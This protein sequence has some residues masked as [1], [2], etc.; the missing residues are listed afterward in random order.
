MVTFLC[1][2]NGVVTMVNKL[3][4]S[5]NNSHFAGLARNL[6]F[7]R[8]FLGRVITD[9]GDTFYYIGAMWLIWEMTNSPFYTGLAGALI[10]IPN[11]LNF[12]VGPLVDRWALQRVLVSTQLI[13]GLGVLLVP[14][15]A[16]TG[17]LSVWLILLLIPFLQFVNG[18]V[19][20][21]Q[22]AALPQIVDKERLVRANSLFST[23]INAIDMV[24]SGIG[25][26]LIATIGAISL[27]VVNSATF[28]I[29]LL[30]FLGITIPKQ[31]NQHEDLDSDE[32]P[33]SNFDDEPSDTNKTGAETDS[34]ETD[35]QNES[36]Y[37][38]ELREGIEYIRGSTLF[39][40]LLAAMFVNSILIAVNAILPA[41]ASSI[42]GPTAYG[43]LAAAI[44]AGN[45]LGSGGSF[46]VEDYPLSWVIIG[47]FILAGCGWTAAIA[48]PGVVPTGILMTLAVIPVGMFNVLFGSMLQTAVENRLLGRVSSIMR[49]FNS[50]LMPAGA[51]L[52]GT[53]AGI[54]GTVTVMYAV[55]GALV[56]FSLYYLI[57]PQLRS[58]PPVTEIDEEM[59]GL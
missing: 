57:H 58:L 59:L 22:N 39:L 4:E 28:A 12:L 14:A 46:L 20:P 16:V 15:A 19:Y 29:A 11:A 10:Q 37:F 2:C 24:A 54:T 43:L 48:V 17:H 53:A 32:V 47:G 7:V 44:G 38:A 27:F 49:T 9:T 1:C 33:D 8:L 3:Q 36:S 31:Q 34:E 41:F 35:S 26:V 18:F 45:L 55:G 23:S 13:N 42:G 6:S 5:L 56:V 50:V 40:M 30:L 51:L 52:G 25:G 21:A